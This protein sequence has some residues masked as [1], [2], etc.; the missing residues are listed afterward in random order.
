MVL[1][2]QESN[3]NDPTLLIGDAMDERVALEAFEGRSL[4]SVKRDIFTARIQLAYIYGNHE[5]AKEMISELSAYHRDRDLVV[6]RKYA[7]DTFSAL[8]AFALARETGEKKYLAHG[9]R[10]LKEFRRQTK[11]GSVNAYP[12]YVFLLAED[13]SITSNDAVS[14]KTLYDEAIKACTRSGLLHMAAMASE[15]AG[16]YFLQIH[17]D[18]LASLH[19]S[20][21]LELYDDWGAS[22]KVSHM[23]QWYDRALL[24][25]TGGA[26]RSATLKAR[27]RYSEED[28]CRIATFN[29]DSKN[30]E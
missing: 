18:S 10:L 29:L 19:L 28:S 22:G 6:A 20:R 9:R 26:Q 4:R 8:V 27:E 30:E 2:L 16:K 12:V 14:V 24:L 23:K 7:R 5:V 25:E 1:N 17:D 11:Q 13:G 3:F 15:S 21:A